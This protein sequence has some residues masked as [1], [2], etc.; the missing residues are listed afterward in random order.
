MSVTAVTISPQ[1]VTYTVEKIE[2]GKTPFNIPGTTILD[3]TRP[4]SVFSIG[5]TQQGV[6]T[7]GGQVVL[8][9]FDKS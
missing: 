5:T 9:S 4:F 1:E 3:D 2:S 6:A 7:G 8:G